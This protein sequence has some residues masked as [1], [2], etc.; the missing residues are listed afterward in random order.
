MKRRAGIPNSIFQ[1]LRHFL[2]YKKHIY[3]APLFFLTAAGCIILIAVLLYNR[4]FSV[5]GDAVQMELDQTSYDFSGTVIVIDPGHG[6]KDPGATSISGVN[7]DVIVFSIARNLRETLE[8]AGA[9]VVLTRNED[10]FAS[11]DQRKVD[12]DLF[13]SLHSD[14]MDDPAVSGFTTYYTHP[15]QKAFAESINQALDRRSYFHNRGVHSM[16]YQV[17]WQLDYPAVLVELGYLS[18]AVDDMVMNE[19]RYQDMM[20]KGIVEGIDDYLN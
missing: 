4:F 14:A 7:E 17:T 3:A 20:V 19:G 1:S 5:S 12:G 11:L 2:K 9:E 10:E 8:D 15:E 16:N 18:N 13:I 6:G